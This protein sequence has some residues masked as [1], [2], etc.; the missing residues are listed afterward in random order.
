MDTTQAKCVVE[1]W[2]SWCRKMTAKGCMVGIAIVAMLVSTSSSLQAQCQP[3][4][5][6]PYTTTMVV[7]TNC[8]PTTVQISYCLPGPGIV[9]PYEYQITGV[10]VLSP[11]GSGCMITGAVMREAGKKLIEQNPYGF[12]CKDNCP[13]VFPTFKI[14]WGTCWRIIAPDRWEP[15]P[16]GGVNQ[17]CADF[18]DVCC[19]CDGTLT[20]FYQSSATSDQCETEYGC[21]TLCA[22][23]APSEPVQC[24]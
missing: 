12:A 17:G 13:K 8:G 10:V 21:K 2:H 11:A 23:P 7:A 18:Y 5:T 19:R 6:G 22:P 4:F 15:C 1:S 9:P 3:G 16:V 20:A 14:G 24:W